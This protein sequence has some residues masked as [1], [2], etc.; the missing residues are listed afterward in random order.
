MC[1]GGS[2]EQNW[3][4]CGR[5]SKL[6]SCATKISTLDSEQ[7]WPSVRLGAERAVESLINALHDDVGIVRDGAAEALG[8]IGDPIAVEPLIEASSKE[9]PKMGLGIQTPDGVV[10]GID[11]TRSARALAKIGEAA[12]EALILTLGAEAKDVLVRSN[13]NSSLGHYP[14]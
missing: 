11:F 12:V 10:H 5:T 9:M 14:R 1:C 4:N 13:S 6:I 8:Q 7:H 2:A 3:S